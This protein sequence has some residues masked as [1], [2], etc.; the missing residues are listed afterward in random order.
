MGAC[1]LDRQPLTVFNGVSFEFRRTYPDN[2]KTIAHENE[3]GPHRS[4]T[5][6]PRSLAVGSTA[7]GLLPYVFSLSPIGQIQPKK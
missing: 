3:R 7:L 4:Y 2:L 5:T 6:R 1:R